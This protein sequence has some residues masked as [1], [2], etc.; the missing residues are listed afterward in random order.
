M[1]TIEFTDQQTETIIKLLSGL[2][3]EEQV[4]YLIELLSGLLKNK[5]GFLKLEKPIL[6]A[7]DSLSMADVIRL[8][9]K[10]GHLT[11]SA[12][13]TLVEKTVLEVQSIE[14]AHELVSNFGGE[15]VFNV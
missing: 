14:M 10:Y 5:N 11:T 9:R 8:A 7:C 3:S 1:K 13:N 4:K 12:T 15:L 2:S 6:I